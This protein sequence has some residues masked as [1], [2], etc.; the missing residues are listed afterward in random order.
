[1]PCDLVASHGRPHRSRCAWPH[2]GVRRGSVR[3]S[4]ARSSWA[5]SRSARLV[6]SILCSSRRRRAASNRRM[7][8]CHPASTAGACAD[9]NP[10]SLASRSRPARRRAIQRALSHG[11]L[12]VSSLEIED[13]DRPL[14]AASRRCVK[15][16][17]RR[18]S[19]NTDP[20]AT[21]ASRVAASWCSS[22]W[23]MPHS[24]GWRLSRHSRHVQRSANFAPTVR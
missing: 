19:R 5:R 17:D 21:R 20:S 8:T 3:S 1:M 24:S 6:S 2:H 16:L 15:P 4:P 22:R 14:R 13:C 10:C 11:A 7:S 12:P 18:S 23:L 9:A